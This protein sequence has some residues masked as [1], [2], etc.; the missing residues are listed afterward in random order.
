MADPQRALVFAMERAELRGFSWHRAPLSYLRRKVR[1]V[2]RA[3][4]IPQATLS[5]R[6]LRS[7]G[8]YLDDAI[9]L[10]V[11]DQNA[12]TCAHELAHH[13]VAHLHPRA[14]D[15][16]ATWAH[17]YGQMLRVFRVMTPAAFAAICRQ[18]G[19]RNCAP[20]H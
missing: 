12:A 4:G 8:E 14:Q 3:Y 20:R 7:G 17:V 19:V 16:G 13:V 18:Y 6:Q 11:G 5:V 9:V 15:H 10:D 1:R 2:C